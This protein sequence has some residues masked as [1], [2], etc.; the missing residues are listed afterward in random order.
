MWKKW[1]QTWEIILISQSNRVFPAQ[2]AV[3]VLDGIVLIFSIVVSM[4]LCFAFV[5]KTVDYTG[6]FSLPLS[7]AYTARRT[8]LLLN[9]PC[10]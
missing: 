7:D 8:F 6:M 9:L 5:L 1:C 2:D 4:G 10:Q 3:L